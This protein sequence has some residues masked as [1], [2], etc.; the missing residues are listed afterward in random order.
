MK[1]LYTNHYIINKKRVFYIMTKKLIAIDLDGTTLNN[2][3]TVAPETFQAIQKLLKKGHIVSIATGRSFRK[4]HHLYNELQLQTPIV[5]YNGAWTHLPN[6]L[7]WQYGY[8]Q[9]LDLNFAFSL[10]KLKKEPEINLIVAETNDKVFVDRPRDRY[11]S[12]YIPF[13]LMD[14]ELLPFNEKHLKVNP[15]SVSVFT[16]AEEN[17]P[18]VKDKIIKQYGNK[19]EVQTWGGRTPTLEIISL[20]IQKAM[21]VERIADYYG[22]KRKDIIAFGD[23]AND[24]EMIQYAGHGVVMK[25][26]IDKLKD[27]SDDITTYTNDENGLARYLTEYFKL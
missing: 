10:L 5:N 18:I 27:V 14:E 16:S 4:S 2:R 15:T 3:S 19:I 25:N 11:L 23:E 6:D 22:I 8:H 20:G 24:Y 21:G 13:Q 12:S 17:I 26:G 9:T 7:D 1:L